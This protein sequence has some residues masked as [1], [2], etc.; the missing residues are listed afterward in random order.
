MV[1]LVRRLSSAAA[2]IVIA[3]ACA[4]GSPPVAEQSPSPLEGG[5]GLIAYVAANGI[6][7]TLSSAQQAACKRNGLD[8]HLRDA[9][10]VTGDTFG[11]RGTSDKGASDK[12]ASDKATPA[13]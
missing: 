8:V 13:A 4:S 7:V 12:S 3:A 10:Q 5:Q 2:L 9:R 6:G 1:T 11:P